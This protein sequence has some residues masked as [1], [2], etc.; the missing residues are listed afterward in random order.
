MIF[1]FASS[2]AYAET[3]FTECNSCT[4]YLHFEYKAED[5]YSQEVSSFRTDILIFNRYTGELRKF[6]VE[7]TPSMGE[8]GVPDIFNIYELTLSS[9]EVSARTKIRNATYSLNNFLGEY[10]A[11]VDK[12]QSVYDLVGI[13]SIENAVV[14]D[15][16]NQ[17]TWNEYVGH[18]FNAGLSMAG[19]IVGVTFVIDV[20]FSDGSTGRF[21]IRGFSSRFDIDFEL[22]AGT[23]NQGNNVPIKKE[24]FEEFGTFVF[25]DDEIGQASMRGLVNAAKNYSINTSMGRISSGSWTCRQTDSGVA[26]TQ[27]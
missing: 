15:I 23:D 13:S 10:V 5:I 22:V 1:S 18:Y 9:A 21:A 19:K 24:H 25:G 12:A 16:R 3:I 27:R 14:N 8:P 7:N 4:S 20:S 17:I 26:C 6:R 2:F 11:P